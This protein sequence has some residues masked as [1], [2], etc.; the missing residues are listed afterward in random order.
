M[1][2]DCT[3]TG[4]LESEFVVARQHIIDIIHLDFS[5]PDGYIVDA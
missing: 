1:W 4:L 2:T 3:C 5:L